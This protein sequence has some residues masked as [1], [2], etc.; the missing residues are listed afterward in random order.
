MGI[1]WS[2]L[3]ALNGVKPPAFLCVTEPLDLQEFIADVTA[4]P[5]PTAWYANL[6]VSSPTI[7]PL[8]HILGPG[9]ISGAYWMTEG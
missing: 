2:P 1:S 5:P 3:C 8:S 7:L 6:T 4:A 9:R